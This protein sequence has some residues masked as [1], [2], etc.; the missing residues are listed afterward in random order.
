MHG[1]VKAGN[2][3]RYLEKT[4]RCVS[5][6][7]VITG[8]SRKWGGRASAS[9]HALS[10]CDRSYHDSVR[11]QRVLGKLLNRIPVVT[12]ESSTDWGLD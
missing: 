8:C 2:V 9:L 7:T 1:E 4:A 3:T 6:S 12:T 5:K 11:R 10:I